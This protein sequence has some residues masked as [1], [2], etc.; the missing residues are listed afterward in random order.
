MWAD[1]ALQWGTAL[2]VVAA[3]FG[4]A[5]T[6]LAEDYYLFGLVYGTTELP[7]GE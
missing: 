4:A 5:E 3:M 6:T 2:V 7:P 1:G